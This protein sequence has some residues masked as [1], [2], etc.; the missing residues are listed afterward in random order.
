[1]KQIKIHDFRHSHAT[2]LI[3]NN[4]PITVI[5]ERLGHADKSITLNT[6]SDLFQ[7]DKNKAVQLINNIR[8][9]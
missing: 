8:K 7:S 9:N 3:S 5:S 6:Y 4:T 2:L 1:M